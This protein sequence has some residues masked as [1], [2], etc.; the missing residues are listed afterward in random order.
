MIPIVN[1]NYDYDKLVKEIE[2]MKKKKDFVEEDSVYLD[3]MTVCADEDQQVIK[4]IEEVASSNLFEEYPRVG[5]NRFGSEPTTKD[6][7]KIA[8]PLPLYG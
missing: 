8:M 1:P 3:G 2:A 7:V 4:H 6:E 5:V